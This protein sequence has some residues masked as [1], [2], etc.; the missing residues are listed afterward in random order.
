MAGGGVLMDHGRHAIY[1][2]HHWFGEEPGKVHASL[3]RPAPRDAEDEAALT[4][5]FPSGRAQIFLTWRGAARRNSMRLIGETG[6][7]AIDDDTLKVGGESI[8]FESALSAG[9][10][11]PDWFAAMLPDII[12][13]L[14]SPE[15]AR[16]SFDEAAVCLAVI[17]RAYQTA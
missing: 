6:E 9:S 5:G 13:S 1:L 12:A 14:R 11:H 8:R 4:L 7:I 17:R 3:H 16:P 10:H 2:A 15:M